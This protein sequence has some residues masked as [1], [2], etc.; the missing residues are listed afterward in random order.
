VFFIE[1]LGNTNALKVWA[2]M[3]PPPSTV[4]ARCA[5]AAAH[6]LLMLLIELLS[7]TIVWEA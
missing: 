4:S 7:G 6:H 3:A 2:A 5:A 1:L